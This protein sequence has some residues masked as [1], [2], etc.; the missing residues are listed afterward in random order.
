MTF[1]ANGFEWLVDARGCDPDALRSRERLE[2][3]FADIVSAA[4]LH[5]LASPQWHVFPGEAGVT[6][7]VMLSE[8][9]L[10]CH[11]YPEAGYAAFSLYCCRPGVPAWDWAGRLRETLGAAEVAVRVVPRGPDHPVEKLDGDTP[12]SVADQGTGN[13][14]F[15]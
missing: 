3:L 10:A 7:L 8:S 13:C 5:A 9:H 15:R 11:T 2:A 6:G 12:W 4:G 14:Q 1:S